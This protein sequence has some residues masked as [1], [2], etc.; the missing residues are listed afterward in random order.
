MGTGNPSTVATHIGQ[1]VFMVVSLIMMSSQLTAVDSCFVSTGRVICIDLVA[2]IR[3]TLPFVYD[4]VTGF[5]TKVTN[6]PVPADGSLGLF[7]LRLARLSIF[8]M[9]LC[10]TLPL[11]QDATVLNA[12][13]VSGTI[14]M[15][16]GPPILMMIF[17]KDSWGV[18]SMVFIS[19]WIAG[20]V[21]GV[22][23]QYQQCVPGT[24]C[25]LKNMKSLLWNRGWEIGTGSYALLL[26]VNLYGILIC[27]GLCFFWFFAYTA[28]YKV[29]GRTPEPAVMFRPSSPEGG[30][31]LDRLRKS[32]DEKAK[33]TDTE[34]V[35]VAVMQPQPSSDSAA[36]AL[37]PAEAVV[38]LES[39]PST[40]QEVVRPE[41]SPAVEITA[42]P[43]PAQPSAD[44]NP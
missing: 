44:D 2:E 30:K 20:L 13:T 14:I 32:S 10:G 35:D 33:P 17:W 37:S 42:E 29:T 21:L 24:L 25:D 8:L 26:G 38:Q 40:Q 9:A 22:L 5:Y 18:R 27:W 43:V 39:S 34:M 4:K 31:A 36:T 3:K 41:S 7:H 23:F 16:C 15:G 19:S 1:S 12:T 28:F 6:D 11:I